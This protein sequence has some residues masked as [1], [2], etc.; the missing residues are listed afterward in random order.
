MK[1]PLFLSEMGDISMFKSLDDIERYIE[2]YGLENDR[3]F[4]AEGT[5][6]GL[7]IVAHEPA[8]VASHWYSRLVQKIHVPV[9]RIVTDSPLPTPRVEFEGILREY[10]S[11]SE[12]DMKLLQSM[13][14]TDMVTFLESTNHFTR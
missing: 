7:Q 1:T 6:F 2:P 4:D 13:C 11:D 8:D 10:L 9:V 12:L 3:V 14:M 5:E